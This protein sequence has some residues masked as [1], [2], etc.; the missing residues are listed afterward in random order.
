MPSSGMQY[1][2]RKLHRSVTEI[3]RSRC[4]RPN[5]STSGC[6]MATRLRG[7]VRDPPSVDQFHLGVEIRIGPGTDER[8][9]GE[10][11]REP[12]PTIGPDQQHPSRHPALA[13]L[14]AGDLRPTTPAGDGVPSATP[15]LGVEARSPAAPSRAPTPPPP[16]GRPAPPGRATPRR[17]SRR[18]T[19]VKRT[20]PA[21]HTMAATASS[22]RRYRRRWAAVRCS[23]TAPAVESVGRGRAHGQ[24]PTASVT[25]ISTRPPRAT[26]SPSGSTARALAPTSALSWCEPCPPA[27]RT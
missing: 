17:A 20:R 13:H 4:T 2:H 22:P 6:P 7:L 21:D 12:D 8:A 26:P 11:H 1:R 3:R 24:A 27:E 9:A 14:H 23:S 18:W 19:R 25:R 15:P 16:A 5:P 10:R